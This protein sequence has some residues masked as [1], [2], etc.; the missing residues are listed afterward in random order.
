MKNL[1]MAITTLMLSGVALAENS[2]EIVKSANQQWNQALNQGELESLIDLYGD[3]ATVSPGDGTLLEGHDDIR[4]LFSGFIEG[5]V[6]NHQIETVKI[7]DAETQIT[8][9]GYWKAEGVNADSQPI[10]F[11][12]VLVTVLEQ[13]DEG[14]WQ[15]QSHVWN[16]TP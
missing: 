16:V 13:N 6:H 9:V 14:E 15:L 1:I 8:Q 2:Q 12:G 11:G 3:S 5:G 10:E 7:I 4:K